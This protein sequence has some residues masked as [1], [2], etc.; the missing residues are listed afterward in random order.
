[1]SIIGVRIYHTKVSV[2]S[3]WTHKVKKEAMKLIV[4]SFVLLLSVEHFI[5]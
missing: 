5:H 4:Q 3:L 1:L 2:R